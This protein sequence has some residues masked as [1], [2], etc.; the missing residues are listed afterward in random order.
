MRYAVIH[1][2]FHHLGVYEDHLHILRAG[3]KKDAHD[4]GIAFRNIEGGD[5]PSYDI[6]CLLMERAIRYPGMMH[7]MTKQ[8]AIVNRYIAE[9]GGDKDCILKY[10]NL[11]FSQWGDYP[12]P[13]PYGMPVFA[14]TFDEAETTCL[15]Q[16]L[17]MVG[18]EW[19]C[20]DCFFCKVGCY[21]TDHA[22]IHCID[23]KVEAKIVRQRKL[24]KKVKA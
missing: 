12:M 16:R 20:A 19:S 4:E 11:R 14:L 10:Y 24:W 13:N 3:L 21:R 22:D 9:H 5:C 2:Q 17:K 18:K 15:E 6:F 23:H 8:Y 1:R 7:G